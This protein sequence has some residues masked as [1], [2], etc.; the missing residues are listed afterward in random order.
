MAVLA[1]E[2]RNKLTFLASRDLE[3]FG[4][5]VEQLVAESSGKEGFGVIPVVHEPFGD[6]QNYG[7]DRFFV[8]LTSGSSTDEALL[9]LFSSLAAKKQPVLSYHVDTTED[10]AGQFFLW[11]MAIAIACALLK[12]NAF[13]QPD[14][15]AAKDKAKSL[16]EVIETKGSLQTKVSTLSLEDFFGDLRPSD[17]VGILAFL[18]DRPE[19][20]N[21]LTGIQAA[22]HNFARNA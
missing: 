19:V 20:R 22:I 17:Y 1:E 14:V 10:L 9:K 5:W 21:A 11:E 18:P 2:G 7:H 6:P 3:S 12:I 13:D 16:L 4:D 8:S 15:Q